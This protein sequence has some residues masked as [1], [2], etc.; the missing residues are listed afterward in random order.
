MG[1]VHAL[2]Y[3]T[4]DWPARKRWLLKVTMIWLKLVVGS[5][6]L[7]TVWIRSTTRNGAVAP[8][9]RVDWSTVKVESP[10]PN[11]VPPA[12]VEKPMFC[13]IAVA[14][15]AVRS[16]ATLKVAFGAAITSAVAS[17]C[18]EAGQNDEYTGAPPPEGTNQQPWKMPAMAVRLP[19]P[20]AGMMYC[21]VADL[22][23]GSPNHI[24]VA[25]D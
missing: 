7:P 25:N 15:T 5:D 22:T 8:V 24:L 14:G 12:P 9:V 17:V 16:A 1:M 4:P 21:E 19:V 10:A 23:T 2:P 3:A 20:V 6:P 18:C 13:P 11:V